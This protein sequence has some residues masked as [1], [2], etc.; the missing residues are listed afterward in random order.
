LI[1]QVDEQFLFTLSWY[2]FAGHCD[3]QIYLYENN[4]GFCGHVPTHVNVEG[5]ASFPVGQT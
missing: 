3:I 1:G 2:V 4:K 5:S